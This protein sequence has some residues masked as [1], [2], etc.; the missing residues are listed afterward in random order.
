[1]AGTA[2]HHVLA[3]EINTNFTRYALFADGR[4]G[5]PGTFATP[6]TDV[7]AFYEALVQVVRKQRAPLDG[8]AISAPGFIDTKT[9]TAR[10]AG[11]LKFLAKQQ[12]G[13]ELAAR[14]GQD[15]PTWLENDANCAAM[16]EKMSG[17]AQ[18]IDDF[19]LV[20]LD[21]GMGGALFLDGKLR[22]GK[23]WRAAEIGQMIINY[24]SAGALPLHDFVSTLKLSQWYA[25]E[26]GGEAGEVLP[27]TLFQ[28][29]DDPRV[30]AI[31]E[32]WVHY[33]AVGIFNTVA[34]VDPEVVLIG[35][36]I[37]RE[38]LLLPML[39]D[40]LDSIRDWKTFKTAI[41]RCR[42][43]GN[44]VLIGAYYAFMEEVGVNA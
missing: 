9:Q 15:I 44:A 38:P 21:T 14:L 31:V 24:D 13:V 26:F 43:S 12:I 5:I 1:M 40:A 36:S 4:M 35:G 18:K 27:S 41:K 17:N 37:S 20:T 39:E 2:Q 42:H 33:I 25:E 28:R 19:V 6:N 32:R 22:R 30:R 23:D 11:A 29:L 7:D 10:T 34:T 3:F 16:A 8:V